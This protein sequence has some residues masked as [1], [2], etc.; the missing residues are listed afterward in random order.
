MRVQGNDV[1]RKNPVSP[2]YDYKLIRS[3]LAHLESARQANDIEGMM[4]LLRGG[5]LRNFGGICDR[6]L[7]LHSCLG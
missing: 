4:Y 5:L 6:R 7:F 2:F 3:Q 1:W